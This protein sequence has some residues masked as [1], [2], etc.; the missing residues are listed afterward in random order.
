[1][2]YSKNEFNGIT[3]FKNTINS[4]DIKVYLYTMPIKDI[5]NKHK[6][7]YAVSRE[8]RKLNKYNKIIVFNEF[9]VG[10]FDKITNWGDIKY[11]NSEFRSIN[12]EIETEKRVLER[13]L[14][15]EL[16]N[17]IDISKY[18][19]NRKSINSR[20]IYIK[21]PLIYKNNLIVKR[22][23]EFD[24]NVESNGD[25]VVGFNLSH[26]FDY[27]NTLDKDLELNNVKEGEKV[28]DYYNNSYYKFVKVAPFSINDE[29]E[30]L[31]CSIVD[32]YK[33]KGESYIVSN[34]NLNTKVVLVKNNKGV[35]FPYIASRL[36]KVC[37]YNNLPGNEIKECNQYIKLNTNDRMKTSI[38]VTLDIL[39]N[40]K[41]IAFNKSNMRSE[42][43]N[44]KKCVLNK[45]K[46]VFGNGK[47]HS[48]ILYGL[49]QLGSYENKE[50]EVSYFIDPDIVKNINKFKKVTD[51]AKEL[52]TF[53]KGI[54]VK[55][56]RVS[57]D[58]NFK[59]LEIK[60]QDSFECELRDIVEKYKNTAIFIMDDL[61]SQKYYKLVKKIFG[62]KNNIA[63]QFIGLSTLNYNSKNR[64]ATLINIL[65]GVYGK[66][67]IQPWILQ[68]PLNADCFIGLDV[69]R[70][71][72]LNTAGIIQ[73]IG[74]DG[75]ILKSKSITS[76]QTGEKIRIETIKEILHE[77]NS[78]YKKVYGKSPNHIVFH[79]DGI[80]REE[81]DL[82]K[83]TAENLG[84]KFD[85]V[86]ITKNI[87]RRIAKIDNTNKIWETE[88]GSYYTKD[89][90]AYIVTTNPYHKLGMAQPIRVTKVH[91]EQS[92]DSIVLDVYKLSFMH[93]GS[94][95]KARLPVTTYYADLS[96]TFGNRGLMPSNIDSNSLHFI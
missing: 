38:Y 62:N 44:Y 91:G 50:I 61:N 48:S 6:E 64:D 57:T 68:E 85:Y 35:V 53:S 19:L 67:G 26:G 22:K 82:L 86:E 10:S 87:Q 18:E 34:L 27:I 31:K 2:N 88:Q 11:I 37:D 40:S 54:G 4:K 81:L 96:S 42:V 41:Y 7:N 8:L 74:K 12:F 69:S 92:I 72:K 93:I 90:K 46:F 24:I 5:N 66:N 43:L 15:E 75:R 45:P 30:Y 23:I 47:T 25:V 28:K 79:R 63:T 49:P 14:L 3:E 83:E 59:E 32:Y 77:V 39:K 21:E 1:M 89:N 33:N 20:S 17:S 58:I 29:N 65:L 73:V 56:K 13:L 60:N 95:L 71:N 9:I 80:S 52:E 94:I 51:F 55:I 36:K 84:I 76:S 16:K 78:S 70:E